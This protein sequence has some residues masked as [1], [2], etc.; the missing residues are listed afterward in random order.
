MSPFLTLSVNM[1]MV[2]GV[3][4]CYLTHTNEGVRI[5]VTGGHPKVVAAMILQ[6]LPP[7]TLTVGD[8]EVEAGGIKVRFMH[9]DPT[10]EDPDVFVAPLPLVGPE[11]THKPMG[12]PLRV[13][14]PLRPVGV[15]L[16]LV[17]FA[18]AGIAFAFAF[19]TGCTS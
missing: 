6:C 4:D 9:V 16:V 11:G 13:R 17:A 7:G 3:T 10:P 14:R 8:T 2:P 1:N 5:E 12:K 18:A 15:A 19:L